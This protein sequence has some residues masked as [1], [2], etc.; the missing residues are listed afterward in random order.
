MARALNHS[1]VN[2]AERMRRNGTERID[3]YGVPPEFYS[4]PKRR[5]SKAAMRAELVEAMERVTRIVRCSGCGHQAAVALPPSRLKAKLRC[6]KCGSI[7][8]TRKEKP[9]GGGGGLNRG[10][11]AG[12]K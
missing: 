1:R 11:L 3:D 4:P 9:A 8:E 10:R 12:Q 7:A 5:P 2:A 6:S